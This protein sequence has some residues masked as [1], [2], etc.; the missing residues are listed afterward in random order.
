MIAERLRPPARYA[1][2]MRNPL[3]WERKTILVELTPEQQD[4]VNTAGATASMVANGWACFQAVAL[5]G[6]GWSYWGGPITA[7]STH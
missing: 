1:V 3:T 7:V 2:E 5:M 4:H 6:E